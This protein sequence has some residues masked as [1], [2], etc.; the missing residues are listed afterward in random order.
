M[1][2]NWANIHWDK[3]IWKYSKIWCKHWKMKHWNEKSKTK[4]IQKD[5]NLDF[6]PLHC[7]RLEK[8][9]KS[10]EQ[11]IPKKS[12]QLWIS[13]HKSYTFI[14]KGPIFG[15]INKIVIIYS[16]KCHKEL[17]DLTIL[18]SLSKSREESFKESRVFRLTSWP[19]SALWKPMSVWKMIHMHHMN[20]WISSNI[21]WEKVN[22]TNYKWWKY[23]K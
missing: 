18:S 9:N 22:G 20:V 5:T 2:F 1:K 16:T 19:N 10:N 8:I 7:V 15:I 23:Y 21:N 17:F 14:V 11:F 13:Q 6:F 4:Q 3:L 12:K